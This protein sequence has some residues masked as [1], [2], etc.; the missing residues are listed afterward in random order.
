MKSA[1]RT[2]PT[3]DSPKRDPVRPTPAQALRQLGLISLVIVVWSGL[4]AAYLN[5]TGTDEQL[6]AELPEPTQA[7]AAAETTAAP[8]PTQQPPTVTAAPSHTAPAPTATAEATASLTALPTE[9]EIP[10]LPTD[11]SLPPEAPSVSFSTDVLPILTSRCQRCHGGDRIEDGLDLMSYAGV[12]AGSENGPVVVPGSSATSS[13]VEVIVSGEMP[14][15]APRLP[16]PEI[17]TIANWVDEG[18]LDN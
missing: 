1:L 15:R 2:H 8:T 14:R 17:Q 12:M 6:V 7:T 16:E 18:A 13:L 9:T 11:T 10:P 4:L 5:L 3:N